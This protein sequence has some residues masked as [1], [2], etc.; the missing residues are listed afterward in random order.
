MSGVKLLDNLVI[1]KRCVSV[2]ICRYAAQERAV[3]I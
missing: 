3:K 2:Y 1:L